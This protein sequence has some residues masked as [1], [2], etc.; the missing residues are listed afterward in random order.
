MR[1]GEERRKVDLYYKHSTQWTRAELYKNFQEKDD[2][3]V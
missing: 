2:T 1:T 3:F